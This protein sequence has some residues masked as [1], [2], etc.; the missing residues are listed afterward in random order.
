M[1]KDVVCD[2]LLEFLLL[3]SVLVCEAN[4]EMG[5]ELIFRKTNFAYAEKPY[6]LLIKEGVI[7]KPDDKT[8]KSLCAGKDFAEAGIE[9]DDLFVVSARYLAYHGID[10]QILTGTENGGKKCLKF[11]L[12]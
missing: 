12:G 5:D 6:Q 4:N 11:I 8:F 3:C 10:W 1:K 7:D 2:A 9:Q